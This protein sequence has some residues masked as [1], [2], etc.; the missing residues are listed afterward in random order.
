MQP[1]IVIHGGAG[2]RLLSATRNA[3]VTASL[4]III[5]H[6][7]KWL[8]AG[9]SATAVA[10]EAARLLE[11]DP[12]YNAGLGSKIQSDGHIRMSASIMDG[13][14]RRFAGCINVENLKNPVLLAQA[15]LKKR[16]RV[17]AEAGAE[18]F[19]DLLK[20]E[21]S[22]PF[23]PH[24]LAEYKRRKEGTSGTIGA[25]VLD[26]KG[27]LAA[28]TSTGGRGY[29]FPH[30]VSDSCTCAGNFANEHA[31]ISLTGTGEE[32]VEAGAAASI[33]SLV[34][35]KIPLHKAA[36]TLLTSAQRRKAGHFG[37]IGM[38]R[39]GHIVARTNTPLLIWAAINGDGAIVMGR[40]HG[41]R[42]RT[43][44]H[45]SLAAKSGRRRRHTD[46]SVGKLS[47]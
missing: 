12:L 19:A 39:Q 36:S 27:R 34:E 33:C 40:K 23:T 6:C 26:Q 8:Q 37:L 7:W 44:S 42:N 10:V 29:E 30:R 31:A 11:D 17:L 2:T 9:R 22:S 3:E 28:A 20:L 16:D 45:R 13:H 4:E 15:L 41:H 21:R 43:D 47:L 46:L 5:Q 38:D 1:G 35:A 25:V 32:I 18:A 24:Q 14:R